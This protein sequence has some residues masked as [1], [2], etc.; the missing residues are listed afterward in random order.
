MT[1]KNINNNVLIGIVFSILCS[2]F[3]NSI[4]AQNIAED[5]KKMNA[6]NIYSEQFMAQLTVKVFS[7]EKDEKPSITQY[8]EIKKKGKDLYYKID[9]KRILVNSSCVLVINDKE[10]KVLYSKNNGKSP[11]NNQSI[12][13]NVDSL[14]KAYD[15]VEFKGITNGLKQYVIHQKKNPIPTIE[16]YFSEN[17]EKLSKLIYHYDTKAY[18]VNNLVEINYTKWT[19]SPQFEANDFSE[20][21]YITKI[22]NKIQLV[23]ALHAYQLVVD[24]YIK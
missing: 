20:K 5:I 22:N 13:V 14:V 1:T 15:N 9:N 10:K 7:S 8:Y 24:D 23:A 2:L 6:A 4:N 3:S 17:G 12:D 21:K 18:P 16:I 11:L 19:Y